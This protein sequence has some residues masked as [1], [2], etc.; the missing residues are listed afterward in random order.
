[1]MR[2]DLTIL[3]AII[4]GL[5]QGLGEFLP[6]SS[7]A[8]LVLVPWL[9]KWSDPG[10]T[11]DIALHIGTLVAVIIYFWEDWLKLIFKGLTDV[12][13]TEGR[14][15][16]YLA[17]ASIPGAV[18]GFLL[19]KKAETIFRE[20]LLIAVMLIVM[21]ILL[22]W[23]DR[24][25]SKN[26]EMSNITFG[27]CILIGISQALAIIPGVSRSGITMTAGLLLGL[28]RKST[29]RFSFL[30]S[31]PIIFG[32]ALVK[33]PYV[34]SHPDMITVNFMVGMLVSSLTGIIS[35]VFLL[36]Y[37]QAKDFLPFVWYRFLLGALVIMAIL[38]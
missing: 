4:L 31:T 13:S 19:E 30:L 17:L 21:G 28:T 29:A 36:R 33:L 9:F 38:V 24:R 32:A 22:Y 26:I 10:L 3:Q 20:P 14:L 8:H 16:W 6:I 34:I 37:V 27:A 23:A 35:I 11:F 12:R 15:F 7:S 2:L 25:S 18:T 1:M 5:V